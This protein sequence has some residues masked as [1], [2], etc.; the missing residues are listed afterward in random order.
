MSPVYTKRVAPGCDTVFEMR[1]EGPQYHKQLRPF[2]ARM[3][4][5]FLP[6]ATRFALAPGYHIPRRWRLWSN[7]CATHSV[8]IVKG[9]RAWR[10]PLAFIFRAVG[11]CGPTL[12][13]PIQYS[14][15]RGDALRACPWLSYSAPFTLVVQLLCKP[16][17]YSSLLAKS[18]FFGGPSNTPCANFNCAIMRISRRSN[19]EV[20]AIARSKSHNAK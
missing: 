2:R 10:L 19:C 7:F 3:F 14:S 9:R 18:G 8:L 1:P 16:I 20:M 4:G 5:L 15:L 11:A 12:C 13:K 6:G 17:Q